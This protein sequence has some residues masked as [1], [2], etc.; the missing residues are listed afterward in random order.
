MHPRLRI[1][2][3]LEARLLPTD[4]IILGGC[5]EGVWPPIAETDAFLNRPMAKALG[6]PSPEQRLGQTA[7]DFCQALGVR[8][9]I[10]TRSS[11]RNGDPMVRSRFL[12]RLQAVI[13]KETTLMLRARG[14]RFLDWARLLDTPVRALPQAQRPSPVPAPDLLPK[15]LSITEIATL[16]RDPYAIYARRILTIDPLEAVNRPVM[17]S[18]LGSAIHDALG[19]FTQ[20]YPLTLPPNAYDDLIALGQHAFTPMHGTAEFEIFWWPRYLRIVQWFI[21]FET[22]HRGDNSQI[23]AEISGRETITLSPTLSMDVHGRADRVE[24]HGDGSFSLY[25]F[26]TGRVPSASEI[27]AKLEPQLT[28]TAALLQKGAFAKITRRQLRLFDYIKLG[29]E[30][31]G[32][33]SDLPKKLADS[34]LDN[35]VAEH[36]AGLQALVKAH[37]LE[38]RGFV[39]RLY[40]PHRGSYGPYDHLARVKEWALGEQEGDA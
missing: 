38:Q 29:G 20:K 22:M 10:L 7:H 33:F 11:K 39:S 17:A 27:K 28:I 25:D 6:L 36:W 5:D 23:F 1:W 40:P 3:L 15:R 24:Q 21:D 34:G 4:R 12:Q 18:D 13:G 9:V 8:D 2:G 26:K 35:L 14:Q 32:E 31:G 30:E 37:W 16:R 19:A